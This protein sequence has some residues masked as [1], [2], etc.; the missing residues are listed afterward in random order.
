MSDD[1]RSKNEMINEII[2]NGKAEFKETQLSPTRDLVN[3]Y[4]MALMVEGK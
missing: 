4:F 1:G 3:A 2:E